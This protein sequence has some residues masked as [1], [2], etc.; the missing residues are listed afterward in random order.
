MTQQPARGDAH[1]VRASQPERWS[2]EKNTHSDTGSGMCV[3]LEDEDNRHGDCSA[4]GRHGG[5]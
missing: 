1:F 2:H 4:F 5:S 3:L